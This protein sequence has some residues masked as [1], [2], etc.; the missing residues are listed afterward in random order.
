M[1]SFGVQ[2]IV[3]VAFIAIMYFLLIRPQ[4]KKENA[5][6]KSILSIVLLSFA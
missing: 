6:V 5:V 4:K 2:L 1:N 3:L